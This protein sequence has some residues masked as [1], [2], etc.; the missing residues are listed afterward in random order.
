MSCRS[1]GRKLCRVAGVATALALL[2]AVASHASVAGRTVGAPRTVTVRLAE[3]NQ[4]GITGKAT[5]REDGGLTTVTVRLRGPAASYLTA[6]HAGGCA[7]FDPVP[8]IPLSDAEP[9]RA[10]RTIVDVSLSDLLAG[11]WVITVHQPVEEFAALLDPASVVACG[12]IREPERPVSPPVTGVG[13]LA[14]EVTPGK[15]ALGLALLAGALAGGGLAL[16]R[17]ARTRVPGSWPS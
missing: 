14:R 6:I 7:R 1:W 11:A 17:P 3:V 2:S 4:S 10:V 9:G 15:L 8:I 16:R 12:E 5:L 13:T